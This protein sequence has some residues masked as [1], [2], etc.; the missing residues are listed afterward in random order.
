MR[1]QKN[2]VVQISKVANLTNYLVFRGIHLAALA[3]V[4]TGM[5][6]RSFAIAFTLYWGRMFVIT[7][8]YHRFFS[9]RA[10]KTSRLVQFII[11]FL[12]TTC[13]Q[14]GPLWWASTHRRHHKYTDE[15]QDVHS[16][17]QRG[18]WYAHVG[19]LG[20]PENGNTDLRLIPDLVRFRELR[21]LD[22]YHWVAP[23]LTAFACFA[24][25]GWQGVSAMAI[26][27]VLFWHAT[28]AIN[29]V[30]HLYGSQPFPQT[31][32][33]SHNWWFL[34]IL[35]MG[36]GW[37]NN[38]HFD[39]NSARQGYRRWWEIDLSYYLL[40]ILAKTRIIWDL[41]QPSPKTHEAVRQQ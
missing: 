12:G 34:A 39:Q 11:G 31:Q 10:Y 21:W 2:T 29:S 7:A 26:S 4:L 13:I 3:V 30:A 38:H 9:H 36:E 19:W 33:D 25:A 23:L 1:K 28:F 22:R 14:K 17:R 35:T 27:T 6:W 18:W 16:P 15:P 40:S 41:R 20:N 37:H 8:G 24:I 5:N 32:D